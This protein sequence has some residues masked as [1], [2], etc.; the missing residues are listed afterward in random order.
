MTSITNR[1]PRRMGGLCAA[2]LLLACT[3][4]TAALAAGVHDPNAVATARPSAPTAPQGAG[5]IVLDFEGLG[6]Q[7]AVNQFYNGGTGGGGSGPGANYGVV[8]S[9][10]SLSI[11]DA[12]AG[13]TGNF[14]GE[15]SPSTVLFFLTGAAATL[16]VAAGF[17]TGFSFFYSAINNPGVI[18][19][20]DGL[21][22][23][24]NLLAT[25]DLPLTPFNGAPDPSGQFSPLVPIGVT[26]AGTARSV[27]FGGTVN[28]VAFDNIT[29]GSGTP[30][31][32]GPPPAPAVPAPTLSPAMLAMLI[33]LLALMG[34]IGW[35][36]TRRR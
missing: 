8:F 16:N 18:R 6:D 36:S 27:D 35:R 23:T 15:P 28:Q 2:A 4:S 1:L 12:D 7:E 25:L 3:V 22:A 19:V 5:S 33:G 31:G 17:T 10:N 11:I 9:D 30:G 21:N 32:G 34:G 14:G 26:F 13:G 29:L 24:G 20:Y